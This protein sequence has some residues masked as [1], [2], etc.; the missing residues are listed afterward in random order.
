MSIQA[1]IKEPEPEPEYD[2]DGYCKTLEKLVALSEKEYYVHVVDINRHQIVTARTLLWLVVV[3]LGFDVALIDWIHNA[4]SDDV[5]NISLY[6]ACSFFL[7]VSAFLGIVAF[8][9]SLL[10][11]PA[12][13]GY[14]P[15]YEKSWADYSN[16]AHALFDKCGQNV[17]LNTLNNILTNIDEA[18][19]VGNQTNADRGIKL[20]FST[21]FS[22]LSGAITI[23]TLIIF[24]FN[25]Y[26]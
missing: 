25:F 2:L 4:I 8:T 16:S 6:Y 13:G 17:Y 19:A 5:R 9:L 10:A 26:T 7:V 1:P 23:V 18:C 21:Y 14:K 22:I 11:I 3:I 24:S 15:L 12:F 20:R